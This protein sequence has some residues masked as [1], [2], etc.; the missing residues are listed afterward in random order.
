MAWIESH[1]SLKDHP[2]LVDL[3]A[4]MS[5]ERD[6]AVGRL[7]MLW[8][9][10]LD[11]AIDGDLQK[12]NDGR[13]AGAMGVAIADA[14]RLV[15]ALVQARWLEREPYFRVHDWW[16]YAGRFLQIKWKHNPEAWKKVR[17]AYLVKAPDPP[18]KTI[19]RFKEPYTNQP[20]QPNQPTNRDSRAREAAGQQGGGGK[21]PAVGPTVESGRWLPDIAHALVWLTDWRNNG[22]DYTEAETRSAFLALSAN[23]WMWGTTPVVDFRAALERQIQTDRQRNEK[24]TNSSKPGTPQRV[25]RSIGT[26]NEG[27]SSQYRGMGKVAGTQ[28]PQRPAA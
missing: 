1:Q 3:C 22:A 20:N 2:K 11:Y 17:E 24:Y 28:H 25:D 27:K 12:H 6:A 26:T 10:C 8:W 4:L 14:K 23:G 13:I 5:W 7:Q 16:T 15:D 9:W 19:E 21:P 18:K